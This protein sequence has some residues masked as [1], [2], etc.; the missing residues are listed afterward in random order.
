MLT[1]KIALT[2]FAQRARALS[3]E[4]GGKPVVVCGYGRGTGGRLWAGYQQLGE[5]RG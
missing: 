5:S 1:R 2:G 4:S 3:E